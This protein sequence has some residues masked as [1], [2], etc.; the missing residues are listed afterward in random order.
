M[1]VH[2]IHQSVQNWHLVTEVGYNKCI[3]P[4]SRQRILGQV[5]LIMVP[6]KEKGEGEGRNKLLYKEAPLQGQNPI[7]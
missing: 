7:N 2:H 5:K 3:I 4:G 1:I 6:G